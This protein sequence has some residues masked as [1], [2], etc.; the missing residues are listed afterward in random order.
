MFPRNCLFTN[1]LYLIYFYYLEYSDNCLHL[2]YY[3][4]NISADASF[5]LHQV[6]H[7]EGCIGQKRCEYNN[8]DED[9]SPNTLSGKNYQASSQKFRQIFN[10]CMYE[11]DFA[12]NNRQVFICHEI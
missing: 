5:G 10:I 12:L 7:F 1:H 4:H 9:N 6:S 11:H 3:I 2:H 8:E